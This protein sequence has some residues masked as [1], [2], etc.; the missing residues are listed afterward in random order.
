MQEMKVVSKV[1]DLKNEKK[2][3]GREDMREERNTKKIEQSRGNTDN[4]S[5]AGDAI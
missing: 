5:E 2:A 1:K 3:W 4:R